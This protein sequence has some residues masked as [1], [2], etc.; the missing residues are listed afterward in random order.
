MYWVYVLS[1]KERGKIYIGQTG[2][3][4]KRVQQHNDPAFTKFGKNAYTK[5]NKGM[6]VLVYK[7]PFSTRSEAIAREK[8]LK[9]HVGRDWLKT[10]I[11]LTKSIS[12]N[13]GR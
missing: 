4:E 3:L 7:E 12:P 1:N 6:W 13:M 10:K 5:I 9:S 2:D 8:Y 11:D